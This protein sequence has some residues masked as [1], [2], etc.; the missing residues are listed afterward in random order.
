MKKPLLI[1]PKLKKTFEV[2]CDACGDILRA[3]LLQEGQPI[4]YEILWLNDN[5]KIFS[6]YEK[7]L[8]VIIHGLKSWNH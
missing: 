6:T 3:S 4:S 1:L 7:E 2:H 5:E 8:L